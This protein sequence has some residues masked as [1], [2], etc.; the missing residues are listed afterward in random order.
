MS[1]PLPLKYINQDSRKKIGKDLV[2]K[3]ENNMFSPY[4]MKDETLEVFRV[5][6]YKGEKCVYLPFS[7]AFQNPSITNI[8]NDNHPKAE[9]YSFTLELNEVQNEIKTELYD[10][11]NRTRSVLISLFT[12][13][14]KSFLGIFIAYKLHYIT[15]ILCHRIPIMEQW[16]KSILISCPNAKVQIV[17]G[18]D[19]L[20]EGM[21][22]YIMNITNVSKKDEDILSKIG[23][24]IVDEA[25]CMATDISIQNILTFHPKYLVALTATPDLV[26]NNSLHLLYGSEWIIREMNRPFNVYLIESSFTPESKQ[27]ERGNLDWNSVLSSQ[28]KSKEFNKIILEVVSYFKRRTIFILCK[29][30]EQTLYLFENLKEMGENVEI[31]IA[32][33]KKYDSKARILISTYSKGGVGMDCPSMDTFIVGSDVMESFS[34][35]L[36]R[37][38]R[39]PH[40]V[41]MV[42]DV[43][44]KNGVM[45]KHYLERRKIYE[46]SGGIVKDL[47]CFPEFKNKIE[48]LIVKKRK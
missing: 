5:Q 32:S 41:P 2:I 26:K 38:F 22:F 7:Y 1:V 17:E 10:I 16:K 44:A 46:K 25:H 23:L 34:Q 33:A 13:A 42:F 15:M 18:K 31:Y 4:A 40:T 29:R 35:Y 45:R 9:K 39:K 48:E 21:D 20:K 12:G 11:L 6:E 27:T 28:A 24:V 37:V 43:L 30:K 47:K 8:Q 36:G 3:C 19:Q 14:G